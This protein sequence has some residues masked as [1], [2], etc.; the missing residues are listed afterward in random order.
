TDCQA[1]ILSITKPYDRH[2]KTP[3]QRHGSAFVALAESAV[4]SFGRLDARV[5][6]QAP[7]W[8]TPTTRPDLC[9]RGEGRGPRA[10]DPDRARTAI[11]VRGLPTSFPLRLFRCRVFARSRRWSGPGKPD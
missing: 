9:P 2:P 10:V 11:S 4:R 6:S 5:C 7:A 8:T 3:A 1:T